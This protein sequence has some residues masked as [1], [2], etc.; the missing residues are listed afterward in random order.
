MVEKSVLI[1][2]LDEFPLV[3]IKSEFELRSFA[4]RILQES[5]FG[6]VLRYITSVQQFEAQKLCV[7]VD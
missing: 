7:K 3:P 2:C 4:F 6:V 1:I 5:N